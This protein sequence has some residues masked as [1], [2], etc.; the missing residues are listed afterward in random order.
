M[1]QDNTLDPPPPHSSVA[2][3]VSARAHV[4]V[5]PYLYVPA[6]QNYFTKQVGRT[7]L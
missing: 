3:A 7:Y 6:F 4:R 1:I 2:G 5:K